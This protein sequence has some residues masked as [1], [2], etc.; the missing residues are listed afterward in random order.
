MIHTC[1]CV[2]VH[3]HTAGSHQDQEKVKAKTTDMKPQGILILTLPGTESKMIM[4]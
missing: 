2:C 3:T 4:Y 1:T